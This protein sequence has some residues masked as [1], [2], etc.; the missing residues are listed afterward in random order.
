MTSAHATYTDFS[1]TWSGECVRNGETLKAKKEISQSNEDSIIIA[2]DTFTLNKP[3][4][5]DL[6]GDD[7]GEWKEVRVY[8]WSWNEEKTQIITNV[9]WLGWYIYQHGTWSGKGN[10]L[11]QLQDDHLVMTRNFDQEF[12]GTSETVAEVCTYS[13]Q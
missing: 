13:R 11:I 7:N 12:N 2:G 4:V 9:H 8:D 10:G 1:G 6:S 5:L 3:T